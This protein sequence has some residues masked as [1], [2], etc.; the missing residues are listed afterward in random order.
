M[1]YI[2][3]LA[4]AA[5][6]STTTLYAQYAPANVK[7]MPVAKECVVEH[8]AT[9]R[10]TNHTIAYKRDIVTVK[11]IPVAQEAQEP[12]TLEM[13]SPDAKERRCIRAKNMAMKDN[14]NSELK[15]YMFGRPAGNYP[16]E[17]KKDLLKNKY[18]VDY[19]MMGCSPVD[20]MLCYNRE[21][22]RLLKRK[23]G[24]H[25]WDKLEKEVEQK[26]KAINRKKK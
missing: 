8:N 6:F 1:R 18:G 23:Y 26:A 5:I 7:G 4:I 10:S 17:I 12:K 21:A 19:M 11:S 13:Y 22:D 16:H 15:Y 9:A 2:T 25:F 24:D 14:Y 20:S 3:L